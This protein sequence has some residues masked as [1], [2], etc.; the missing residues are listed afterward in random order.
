MAWGYN[1]EGQ[2]GNGTTESS[3][4]PVPVPGLSG[5]TAIA[6]GG[7][8]SL[9]LLSNGK[10]M[11]WGE[12]NHGQLGHPSIARSLVPVEAELSGVKAIAA[13]WDH[14]L[15]VLSNGTVMSWGYNHEGELGHGLKDEYEIFPQPVCAVGESYPCT[16]NQL[17]G[18]VAVSASST[19][20]MA[21]LSNGTI[22]AWGNNAWGV[23][24]TGASSESDVPVLVSGVSEVTAIAAGE[25]YALD[26]SR[27]GTVRGWG[28]GLDGQLGD[29]T[30]ETSESPVLVSGLSG[31]T[32]IGAGHN[33]SIALAAPPTP[34]P[35]ILSVTPNQGPPGGGTAV[36]IKGVNF[37]GATAVKFGSSNAASFEVVSETEIR[38]VTPA[39][40]G[41]VA[42]TVINPAGESPETGNT[43]FTFNLRP[44]IRSVEPDHGPPSGGT[45]VTITGKHFVG[46]SEVKFGSTEAR[47]FTVQSETQITAVSPAFGG[48]GEDAGPI[49]VTTAEGTNKADEVGSLKTTG[50]IYE[51][52]ISKIEPSS[53]PGP[54]APR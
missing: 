18:A 48:G 16:K 36:T 10:V 20:S 38:A 53:G 23:L 39:G 13:A 3:D 12:N 32:A 50:F 6:A 29:R 19:F 34:Y 44:Q 35:R 4:V 46:V 7:E 28:D 47:S 9:A 43:G 30:Y 45:T 25:N 54:A 8:Y 26:L 37:T 11:A 1:K 33:T 42:V 17:T 21:L 41:F 15:A 14:S 49:F 5:V 52:T 22:A 40:S 31:A 2:L 27:D 24:G 51:P